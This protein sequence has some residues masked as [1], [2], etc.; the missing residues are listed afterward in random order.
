MKD[1]KDDKKSQ[2]NLYET[3]N[4]LKLRLKIKLKDKEFEIESKSNI[5]IHKRKK[6]PFIKRNSSNYDKYSSLDSENKKSNKN[7]E[8]NN[9]NN[10]EEKKHNKTCGTPKKRINSKRHKKETQPFNIKEELKDILVNKTH[11]IKVTQSNTIKSNNNNELKINR[12]DSNDAI[13]IFK[14]ETNEEINARLDKLINKL[15]LAKEYKPNTEIDL[16]ENEINW[17]IIKAY[18]I[19]KNQPVFIELDSPITVCGDVHGQF[20]DLL[21]LFNYV[22]FP[23]KSNFLFLGDYVDRGKNS[24][25]TIVLLLCYKIKYPENFFMLRGNHESENINT[26][27]GFFDEC[28]RRFNIKIWKKFNDLFNIFPITAIIKDKILCMHGGLSPNLLSFDLLKKI[29]RPTEIP[30]SGLLCDLLWSDPDENIEKWGDN[31]RGVS[32]T[33]SE[34]IVEDFL[35]KYDLDLIC[36]GH[37]VVE[38]GYEFFANRQ[39]VTIFSAPNYCGEFDNAG[40]MML[41]DKD[42]MCTF[43]VLKPITSSSNNNYLHRPGTPPKFKNK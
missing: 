18:E 22:G 10:E 34:K 24:L 27:Y 36:R 38:N 32:Y 6:S 39:L 3:K 11:N 20:Y 29:V 31:E 9:I 14:K 12:F 37:Q 41:I 15:L 1:E 43:K 26:I 35:D 4:S 17:V 16:L 33:F 5:N 23:P 7:S 2:K 40:A 19:I 21:R 25:E 13:R 42:L 28:K 30:D 8:N